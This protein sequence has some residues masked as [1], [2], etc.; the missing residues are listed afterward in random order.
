LGGRWGLVGGEH[1]VGRIEGE[2]V[3]LRVGGKVGKTSRG[4]GGYPAYGA[5]GDTC[6][7]VQLEITEGIGN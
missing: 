1:N 2:V 5:G 6:L 3:E 4:K 7:F